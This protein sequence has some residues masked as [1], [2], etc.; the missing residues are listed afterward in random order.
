MLS[1]LEASVEELTA[2]NAVTLAAIVRILESKGIL[3]REEIMAEI[4]KIRLEQEVS[5]P[6]D[7]IEV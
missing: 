1:E 6:H 2:A 4:K 3:D 5:E 7:E